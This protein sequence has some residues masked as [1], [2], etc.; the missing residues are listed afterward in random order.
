MTP[1]SPSPPWRRDSSLLLMAV[2]GIAFATAGL[3]LARPHLVAIATPLLLGVTWSA[4]NRPDGPVHVTTSSTTTTLRSDELDTTLTIT[5]PP[6]AT[7][8]RVLVASP[9]TA[10]TETMV[11]IDRTRDLRVTTPSVRTGTRELF[12][13]DLIAT[14]THGGWHNGIHHVQPEHVLVLPAAH[15]TTALPV[16]EHLRGLTGEH[17]SR[18]LGDGSELRD[19]APYN[20]GDPLR[21]IDWRVTARRSPDADHLYVRRTYASAEAC[22]V[23]AVDSR[24]DVGPEI[25]TWGS[26]G[27]VR[28]D[29]Q[30]SLDIAR[31]AAATIA[32]AVIDAGDR[33]GLEDLGRLHTPVPLAGG[34]RHLQRIYHALALSQPHGAPRIRERAPQVPH[35]AL[36]YLFSTFLDDSSVTIAHQWHAHGHRVIVIDTLPTEDFWGLSEREHLAWRLTEIARQDRLTALISNGITVLRW[37]DPTTRAALQATARERRPRR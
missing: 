10:R 8:A 1:P 33:V 20:P 37:T 12:T 16:S 21:R 22:V 24:D 9:G 2:T 15:R 23:L 13:T 34:K 6:G 31:E 14:S 32:R 11:H 19:I 18:R 17:R 26:F 7:I 35:G 28:P 30:T 5:A 36:V 27:A 4:W 3:L 29:Q 25:A